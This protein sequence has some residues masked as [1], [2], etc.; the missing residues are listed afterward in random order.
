MYNE[1]LAVLVAGS[2]G[3]NPLELLGGE[4]LKGLVAAASKHFRVIVVDTPAA[5]TGPDLEIF[6][7][8]AAGALIVA[9]RG[10]ARPL[11]RLRNALARSNAAALSIVVNQRQAEA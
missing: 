4:R 5:E 8:M 7:A 6:A 2:A 11:T 1:N 9:R 3:R 10:K